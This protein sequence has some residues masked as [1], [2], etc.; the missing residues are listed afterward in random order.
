M[1]KYK[2]RNEVPVVAIFSNLNTFIY[3]ITAPQRLV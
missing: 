1:V 3:C 2:S